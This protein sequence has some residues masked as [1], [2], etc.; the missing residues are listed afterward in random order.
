MAS[1][2]SSTTGPVS[3]VGASARVD[4]IS[5]QGN[6]SLLVSE[7]PLAQA[8]QLLLGE[9][10]A[11][12]VLDRLPGERLLVQVKAGLLTLQLPAAKPD[13]DPGA[14]GSAE[15]AIARNLAQASVGSSLSLKVASLSPRLAFVVAPPAEAPASANTSAAV[16]FSTA[17][18]YLTDLL[19]AAPTGAQSS[20]PL[21]AAGAGLLPG[22]PTASAAQRADALAQAVQGSGLFYESHLRAWA[23]G[24][25]PLDALKSEPQAQ[26]ADA[27][28]SASPAERE[29]AA[30][31][32]GGLVQR[33]L[34][35][36]D[37]RPLAFSAAAWPGQPVD[38]HFEREASDTGDD[39]A[40]QQR[41]DDG[42]EAPPTWSTR[43]QL[44][45]PRLGALG[46]QVRVVGE[47]VTLL[48]TTGDDA[49]AGLFSAHRARLAAALHSAGLSLA[50]M[51]VVPSPA[52]A[53]GQAP[54]TM[55]APPSGGV[56]GK[57]T[58]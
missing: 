44:S 25:L 45:L 18:L 40:A 3:G 51:N 36:L 57:A 22:D 12:R 8:P 7:T 4:A 50:T 52:H 41:P 32:L 48:M 38:L 43:I 10:V 6:R 1:S 30:S 31:V 33:Q 23:E 42:A 46:A 27:L 58:P 21:A 34:D 35:A 37:G 17:A 39:E 9:S 19:H 26:A 14:A 2:P 56:A 13:A 16:Q 11:A 5:G 54:P 53:P 24:R 28:K 20:T 47:Q 29:R 55:G 15:A 49:T